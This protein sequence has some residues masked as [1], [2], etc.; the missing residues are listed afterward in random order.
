MCVEAAPLA[1]VV[2]DMAIDVLVADADHAVEA[3]SADDL[4]RTPA[5]AQP[6]IGHPA[7][8]GLRSASFVGSKS[9][10]AGCDNRLS[11]VGTHR[12]CADCGDSPG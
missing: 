6:G 12:R 7:D 11:W 4:L 5:Y 8:D 10:I 9:V 1:A 3:Q 2:P